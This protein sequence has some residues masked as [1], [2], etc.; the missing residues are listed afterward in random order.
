MNVDRPL[1]TKNKE[2]NTIMAQQVELTISKREV[3][4]KKT[5]HLRKAGIIPANIYGHHEASEAVQ[6]DALAFDALRRAHKI[7]GIISLRIDGHKSSQTAL[8]RHI[9]RHPTSSKIL[10]IDFFRVSLRERIVMKIPIHTLGEAPGV[11][12][13]DGVLLH[14]L[15]MLEVEC[16]AQDIVNALEVDVSSLAHIDDILYAKDVKLPEGFKLITD[17]EEP[18]VKVAATRAEKA[19]EAEEEKEAAASAPAGETPA[20]TGTEE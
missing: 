19:E 7:S 16:M 17:P 6:V 4:G 20:E 10:H 9:Q 2:G 12:D 14:L 18:I 11:K 8:V 13:E 5:K 3:T 15:D 1:T